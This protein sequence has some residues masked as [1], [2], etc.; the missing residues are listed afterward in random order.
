MPGSLRRRA[1]LVLALVCSAILLSGSGVLSGWA[2][3]L[4][5]DVAQL[6][7]GVAAALTCFATA[8]R[9]VG[10]ERRWRQLMG[11]GMAGWS[12]GV[13]FWG[14][15]RSFLQ[16]PLPSPSLADVGFFA[17]PVMA[18]P[19]LLTLSGVSPRRAAVGSRHL[20]AIW[21]IDSLVVVCS[22]FVI[23]WMTALG[24][25]VRAGAPTDL[26]FVIAVG[27]PVL[28]YL[29]I[30][31]LVLL[32]VTG[33][34][35]SHLRVQ[36]SLLGSGIAMVALSDSVFTYIVSSG[37]AAMPTITD[38][39]F[40]AG[41]AFIALAAAAPRGPNTP[42]DPRRTAVI[43]RATLVVP[44]VLVGGI[45]TLITGQL[46]AD[47][48]VGPIE[49]VIGWVVLILVLVRQVLTLLENNALVHRISLT[50]AELTHQAHHDPLTGLANRTLFDAR[51]HRAT[52]RHRDEHRPLALLLLDL[53]DFKAVNDQL[54]HGCGDELLQAV[55]ARL[56][57]AIRT[58]DTAARL[59]GD[60]F[61]VL[62]DPGPEDPYTIARRIHDHV[63][64]GYEIEGRMLAVGVSAGLALPEPD[65]TEVTAEIMLRR[66]DLAMYDGKRRGKSLLV[67]YRP[68]IV[69]D[70]TPELY[71]RGTSPK[72]VAGEPEPALFNGPPT[73]T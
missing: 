26:G 61:A 70:R 66:A 3:V 60:E 49:L 13:V 6:V 38:A 30:T 12:V 59:G 25:V 44:Y 1:V 50:Q 35:P 69:G 23:T 14:V 68:T 19:A 63:Q 24:A 54:G 37:T 72:I 58:V 32:W 31:V 22:L 7:G 21:V 55:G 52:H 47:T 5:D 10:P 34:V 65:E 36:L 41:P 51:L 62:L 56:R 67:H 15:Y 27:Y 45:W 20:W 29:G 18:V 73:S 8:A 17:L 64:A 53:D 71:R 40:I 9:A 46:V 33:R 42:E 39:G 2:S 48:A 57:S 11:V 28:D 43:E 4:V 16:T